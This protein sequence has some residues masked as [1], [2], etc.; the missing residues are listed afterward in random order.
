MKH[1]VFSKTN[2]ISMSKSILRE[3]FKF[4]VGNLEV[5]GCLPYLYSHPFIVGRPHFISH[6]EAC[7]FYLN[8]DDQHVEAHGPDQVSE[9]R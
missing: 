2:L 3:S 4:V 8:G 5:M 9:W 7:D 6:N 1:D